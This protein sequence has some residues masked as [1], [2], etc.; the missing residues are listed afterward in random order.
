M[1]WSRN[2]EFHVYDD[3]DGAAISEESIEKR[4]YS[5][6]LTCLHK[7]LLSFLFLVILSFFA[8]IWAWPQ[9]NVA[10]VCFT[11]WIFLIS[12]E[13]KGCHNEIVEYLYVHCFMWVARFDVIFVF[14]S[15]NKAL[16]SSI[17]WVRWLFGLDYTIN[18]ISMI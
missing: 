12:S 16:R 2:M 5:L 17:K 4:T 8:P 9:V 15:P 3:G 13:E 18:D 11:D 6:Q 1:P 7:L 14:R 10:E